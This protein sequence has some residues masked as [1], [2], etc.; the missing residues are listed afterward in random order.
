MVNF[1]IIIWKDQ[2]IDILRDQGDFEQFDVEPVMY[3]NF[4]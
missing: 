2:H 1:G 3:Y 4:Y